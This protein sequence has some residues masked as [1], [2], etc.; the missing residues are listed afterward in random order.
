V[1]ELRRWEEREEVVAAVEERLQFFPTHS[2]MASAE[3]EE[4]FFCLFPWCVL[5]RAE[6][7]GATTSR[8]DSGNC[9]YRHGLDRSHAIKE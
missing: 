7:R 4:G 2:F 9:V 3:E 6:G 1:W 8:E 5:I